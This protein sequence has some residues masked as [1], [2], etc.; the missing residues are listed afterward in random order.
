MPNRP[1]YIATST[2]VGAGY[3]LYKVHNKNS[4]ARIFETAGGALGGYLGGILPDPIDPPLHPGH[5]SLGHGFCPVVAGT[6]VWN[7]G[8]HDWQ[9]H[10]RQLADQHAYWRARSTGFATSAWHVC[11]EWVL[12]L[13][14][15]FLTGIGA[16]YLTH[17][18]LDAATPR[19]PLVC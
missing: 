4:L 7:Q 11:A 13:L 19:L 8:I 16:R 3:A 1:L 6:V 15:G 14:S 12:R 10:L 5:C 17:V 9:D 18:V 2:P